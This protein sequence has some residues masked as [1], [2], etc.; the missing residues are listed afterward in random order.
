MIVCIVFK[1]RFSSYS[2]KLE[3]ARYKL[4]VQIQKQWT[5]VAIRCRNSSPTAATITCRRLVW[6]AA[7]HLASHLWG[8][9][10]KKLENAEGCSVGSWGQVHVLATSKGSAVH[11]WRTWV[12]GPGSLGVNPA[13]VTSYLLVPLW[14]GDDDRVDVGIRWDGL[15]KVHSQAWP[16]GNAW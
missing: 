1:S 14:S 2:W 8:I 3:L 11:W 7:S 4:V 13:T 9:A 15:S 16:R 12:L 6:E 10:S 5:P